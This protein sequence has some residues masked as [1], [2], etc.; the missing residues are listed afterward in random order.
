LSVRARHPNPNLREDKKVFRVS[1]EPCSEM[2]G[3]ENEIVRSPA[4]VS[5]KGRLPTKQGLRESG[6]ESRKGFW[7]KRGMLGRGGRKSSGGNVVQ[8]TKFAKKTRA[9][10]GRSHR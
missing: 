9:Q 4:G 5:K 3:G 8:K 6:G 7:G 10:R 1:R 2:W